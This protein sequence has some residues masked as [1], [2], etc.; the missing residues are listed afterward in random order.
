MTYCGVMRKRSAIPGVLMLIFSAVLFSIVLPAGYD[1]GLSLF[2]FTVVTAFT[3]LGILSGISVGK[4]MAYTV[5]DR[6]LM[7]ERLGGKGTITGAFGMATDLSL[8]IGAFFLV[9]WTVFTIL[10]SFLEGAVTDRIL[11]G[12]VRW[13]SILAMITMITGSYLLFRA[14]ASEKRRML[15]FWGKRAEMPAGM[16]EKMERGVDYVEAQARAIPGKGLRMAAD[17]ADRAD[18]MLRGR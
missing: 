3:L 8:F 1:A 13:L 18:N 16:G 12:Y 2:M 11:L 7:A 4:K 10:L 5:H 14:R 9:G 6:E 15:S 17:A